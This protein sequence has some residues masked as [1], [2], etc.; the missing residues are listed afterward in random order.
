MSDSH[1]NAEL[2]RS[3]KQLAG[4]C[5]EYCL[6][7]QLYNAIPF[8]V[9]HITAEKHGGLTVLMNLALACLYCNTFKGSDIASNDPLTGDLARLYNPRTQQWA[10]HFILHGAR[11]EPL[12][13]EGRV[14]VKLLRLNEASRILER[15]RLL[16]RGK[17][18]CQIPV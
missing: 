2:R 16:L 10:D 7:S 15:Q 14:S 17:Y 1:I 11:I 6:L 8:H 12:S 18:P 9:D 13:P 4:H 5:C 3:I